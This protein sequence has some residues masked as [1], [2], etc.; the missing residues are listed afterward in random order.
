[1]RKVEEQGRAKKK[2]PGYT[3]FYQKLHNGLGWINPG[4]GTGESQAHGGRELE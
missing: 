2:R 4:T 3:I 1:M